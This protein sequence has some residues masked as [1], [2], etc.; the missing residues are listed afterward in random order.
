MNC[1]S[2]IYLDCSISNHEKDILIK[3]YS[4]IRADDPGNTK[5]GGVCIYYKETLGAHIIDIPNLRVYFLSSYNK[6]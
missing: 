3:G 2:E 5:G 4:L 1:G 6:K